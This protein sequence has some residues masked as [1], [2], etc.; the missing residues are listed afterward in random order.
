MRGFFSSDDEGKNA[1]KCNQVIRTA[2]ISLLSVMMCTAVI[3]LSGCERQNTLDIMAETET[4]PAQEEQP[5]GS[6]D[7]G[8]G[9]AAPETGK[10][11]AEKGAAAAETEP[12]D[13]KN[14]ASAEAVWYIHVCGAVS[15]PGV[16]EL[17][18]GSRCFEAVQKAGGFTAD[19]AQ[20]YVNMAEILSDGVRLEIPTKEQAAQVQK[21]NTGKAGFGK[22]ESAAGAGTNASAAGMAKVNINTADISQLCTLSGVGESRAKN[23]IA[24]RE[25]H[26]SFQNCEDLMQVTGIKEGLYSKIKD[27]ICVR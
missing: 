8:N 24:Y 18:E 21:E 3:L 25:A 4:V 5:A 20:N 2:G 10:S 17:P 12:S 11:G 27:Q 1:M 6:T 7:A 9:A 16:Y 14:R 23:I 15:N 19:A 13:G 22:T 26:G